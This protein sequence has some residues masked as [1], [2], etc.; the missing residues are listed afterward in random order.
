MSH[1][2]SA[3]LADRFKFCSPRRQEDGRAGL[4]S[5]ACVHPNKGSAQHLIMTKD[6]RARV[7]SFSSLSEIS[8]KMP[9]NGWWGQGQLVCIQMSCPVP[10]PAGTGSASLM[11]PQDLEVVS[12]SRLVMDA[13]VPPAG[14]GPM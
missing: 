12:D 14:V 3:L 7:G 9:A 6:P 5:S 8:R 1:A 4:Q 10:G 11:T 2:R 13:S